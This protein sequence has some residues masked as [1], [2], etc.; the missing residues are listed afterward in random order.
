MVVK[1]SSGCGW[2]GGG[3]PGVFPSEHVSGYFFR[4]VGISDGALASLRYRAGSTK[5]YRACIRGYM[6]DHW[7]CTRWHD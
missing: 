3:P 5:P 1:S 2:A 4:Q 6:S 7:T